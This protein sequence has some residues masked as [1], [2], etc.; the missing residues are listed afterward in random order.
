M[1][2]QLQRAASPLVATVAAADAWD[3]AGPSS[4]HCYCGCNNDCWPAAVAAAQVEPRNTVQKADL[5]DQAEGMGSWAV[6][7]PT[8]SLECHSHSENCT[9]AP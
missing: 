1:F 9:L 6:V 2:V 8:M 3:A 7:V 5:C 4:Q